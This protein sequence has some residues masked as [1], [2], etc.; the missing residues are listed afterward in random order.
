MGLIMVFSLI[1][2]R[3]LLQELD[4]EDYGVY[5]AIGGVVTSFALISGVLSGASQRFF[6]YS[7]GLNDIEGLKRTMS[8]I[9]FLYTIVI[10]IILIIAE[11]IGLWFV[12]NKMVY[13]EDMR[14]S[15]FWI[16]QLSLLSFLVTIAYTPLIAIIISHE[17]M[18]IYAVISIIDGVLKL[19][20]VLSLGLFH[21]HKIVYYPL[22]LSIISIMT[23]ASYFIV[24]KRKY[25]YIDL[26]IAYDKTTFKSILGFSSWSLVGSIANVIYHQGI[27]L[28]FNLFIGPIANAAFAIA[29][30]VNVAVN[31]L[32]TSFFS[33]VRP[34]IIKSYARNDYDSLPKLFIFSSKLMFIL[35]FAIV[36]P[37]ITITS[38]ILHIWL[39]EVTTYT[40][41]FVQ[42]MTIVGLILCL[43]LPF[44]TI[45]QASGK[46]KYYHIYVDGFISV[47]LVGIYYILKSGLS[48]NFVLYYV[49]TITF[50][51]HIIRILYLIYYL[52]F[53]LKGYLMKFCLPTAIIGISSYVVVN[54]VAN[55]ISFTPI[56]NIV[57]V[58][59]FSVVCIVLLSFLFLIN[60][61]ER[62]II[63]NLLMK[64]Y[65]NANSEK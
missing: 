44:T 38:D 41:S 56:L 19:S 4:V 39:G 29:N 14:N 8:S 50:I 48:S 54:A 31:T 59:C 33:A 53:P 61:Q 16:Y 11:T 55:H 13:P 12:M 5:N 27:N 43:G 2:V 46:I 32:G 52:K 37:I 1:S 18:N 64:K 45:A 49:V 22:L 65:Y 35:L 42:K 21:S 57:C 9:I 60:A 23:F 47:S 63:I 62:G 30:Q 7:L 15:V 25:S 40:V 51:A 28:I 3:F 17:E 20:C 26:S 34:G 10:I 6:S 24:V 58:I 36:L